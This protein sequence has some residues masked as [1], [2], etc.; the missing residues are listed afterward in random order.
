MDPPKTSELTTEKNKHLLTLY[1]IVPSKG[2]L[3]YHQLE[4]RK[5]FDS[6]DFA[7]AQAHRS[8]DI[9]TVTTGSEYPIRRDISDPSSSVTSSGN[10]DD[11]ANQHSPTEKKTGE[12]KLTSHSHLQQEMEAQ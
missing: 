7:L 6:G 9:G 1:G 3:L 4:R 12:L 10:L 11:N 8:S 5:Y 2:N